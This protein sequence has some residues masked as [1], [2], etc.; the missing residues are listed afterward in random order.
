M[1]AIMIKNQSNKEKTIKTELIASR[2]DAW[3]IDNFSLYSNYLGTVIL[4]DGFILDE[5]R[6]HFDNLLQE[7]DLDEKYHYSPTLFS[8]DY[9]GTPD[10]DFLVL[11]FARM[12]T[13]FEFN[14]DKIRILPLTAM[15]DINKL[16]VH[17]K[18]AV[19][20]SRTNPPA[21]Q[22]FDSL[23]EVKQVYLGYTET[24]K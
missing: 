22:E 16:M 20:N 11:Y 3:K 6:D 8:E 23:E 15:V 14:T 4:P 19:M 13:L 21:Y 12:K 2:G 9:Y 5:Y 24:T 7:I 10:L 17:Y 18:E 1:W